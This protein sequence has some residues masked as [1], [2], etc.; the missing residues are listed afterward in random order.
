LFTVGGGMPFDKKPETSA[1]SSSYDSNM[2]TLNGNTGRMQS[3]MGS[4]L[5]P[6][7]SSSLMSYIKL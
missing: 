5:E 2:M 3:E 6:G 4:A 7:A 1:V